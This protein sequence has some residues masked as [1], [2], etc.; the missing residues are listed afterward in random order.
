MESGLK[1]LSDVPMTDGKINVSQVRALLLNS[2]TQSNCF[3]QCCI[4]QKLIKFF[5]KDVGVQ[6]TLHPALILQTKRLL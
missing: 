2:A 1:T 4:L 3:L 5:S 6:F